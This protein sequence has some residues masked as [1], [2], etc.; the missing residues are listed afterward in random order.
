[1]GFADPFVAGL[2]AAADSIAG[3]KSGSANFAHDDAPAQSLEPQQFP[4][5]PLRRALAF[6]TITR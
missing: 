5:T 6:A 1:M 2:A 3:L 4:G